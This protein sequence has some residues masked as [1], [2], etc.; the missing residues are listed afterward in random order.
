M[1]NLP[2]AEILNIGDEI[3]IGQIVN[4]NAV[5]IAQELNKRGVP[6]K[7]MTTVG[8]NKADMVKAI[9][10]AIQHHDIL[11]ITGGLGPTKDDLT[12]EVLTEYF[13]T[14]LVFNHEV[15]ELL[16]NFFKKRGR[17]LNEANKTQCYV[18]K[19]CT[20]LMNYWGTA[21]GM[22][23]KKEGKIIVSLPGVPLEMKE[24]MNK[25]VFPY[26]ETHYP[27]PPILHRSYLTEGI[28]ESELMMK[29]AEWEN[30]LPTSVKLAYLP[31]AGQVTLRLSTLNENGNG[32]AIIQEQ[33]EK[34][35]SILEDEIIGYDGDT[36]EQVI[37]RIFIEKRLTLGTAESCT[38]GYIAHKITSVPGSSAYFMGSVVSYHNR[39]K[40]EVLKGKED[41]L[42]TVGAVS[43]E[44]VIQMAEHVRAIL[45]T[46]YA[47]AVSGIAGPDGGTPEKPV[48]TVWV[49][50][51]TPQGTLTKKYRFGNDRLTNIHR[52]YQAS[53]G[54][55]RKLVLN[56][57]VREN[58]WE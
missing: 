11:I 6:V 52:T 46:D 26:I 45:Q 4:T 7:R 42:K 58:F 31:S 54:V 41:T 56:I 40:Q 35:K 8:D 15:F 49:A 34:L 22:L 53:L 19:N 51:A 27:L 38:G 57:P 33:E 30:N 24:L 39:V 20:I 9:D 1:K 44:T 10:Q 55:L 16:D 29:L 12:K 48:G 13:Q 50:W 14:Q 23:F 17:I 28:P 3:L 21:P 32:R 43:K 5:W 25:Y 18:P 2:Q 37:Q 36:L 47:I